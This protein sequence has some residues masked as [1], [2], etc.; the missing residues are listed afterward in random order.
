MGFV[1]PPYMRLVANK[2]QIPV[3]TDNFINTLTD[4]VYAKSI[5][6]CF[7]EGVSEVCQTYRHLAQMGCGGSELAST[8]I[9][10]AKQLSIVVHQFSY[11]L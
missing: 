8:G 3:L 1:K 7:A 11:F 10:I 2:A 5:K 6:V 4:Y 9:W